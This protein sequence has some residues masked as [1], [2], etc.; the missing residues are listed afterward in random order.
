MHTQKITKKTTERKNGY[1]YDWNN[2]FYKWAEGVKD[3]YKV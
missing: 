3:L 2:G 1:L